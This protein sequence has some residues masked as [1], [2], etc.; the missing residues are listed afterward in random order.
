VL[1]EPDAALRASRLR[2]AAAVG[3]QLAAVLNLLGIDAP[4]RM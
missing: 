1:D 4:D 3:D 2:L